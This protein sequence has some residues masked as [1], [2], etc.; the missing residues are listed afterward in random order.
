MTTRLKQWLYLLAGSLGLCLSPSHILTVGSAS[1][2][3]SDCVKYLAVTLDHHLTMKTHISNLVCLANFELCHISSI[4]H[5]P[6]TGATKILVSA[7]V[8]SHLDYCNSL[9]SRCPQY[10]LNKVRDI[11]LTLHHLEQSPFPN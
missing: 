6:T 11:F 4:R 9:L 7:F 5:L 10:L 1:V 2:P 3:M 8:L